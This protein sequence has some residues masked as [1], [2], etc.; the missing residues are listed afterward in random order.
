MFSPQPIN[1]DNGDCEIESGSRPLRNIRRP[2]KYDAFDTQFANS[3]YV[4][5][6]R[7]DI[8]RDT[9]LSSEKLSTQ[10]CDMTSHG[11]RALIGPGGCLGQASSRAIYE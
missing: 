3:Q 5:R 1:L 6:I 4:R 11:S 8:S 9:S 2:A 7:V 10:A